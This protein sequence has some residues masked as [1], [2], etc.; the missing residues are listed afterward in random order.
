[1]K[2]AFLA[3][4][5]LLALITAQSASAADLSLK[6]APVTSPYVPMV[7]DWTGLYVT[8]H[9]GGMWGSIVGCCVN[10]ATI[11]TGIGYNW[12]AGRFVYGLEGDW[13][14]YAMAGIF[15]FQYALDVRARVGYTFDRV[16][17]FIAFGYSDGRIGPGPLASTPYTWRSGFT[18]GGGV[19]YWATPDLSTKME[20]LY[21]DYGS[22]APV[23]P[24]VTAQNYVVRAG[25]TY[26][27]KPL[28]NW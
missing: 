27:F 12:Q 8:G 16:L 25:L 10:G 20:Y 19:E 11:G 4:V 26:H 17:P 18:V 9:A 15:Q 21:N 23:V 1:M 24:S 2:R 22:V 13:D 14:W 28:L 5:G 3:S 7:P 6:A